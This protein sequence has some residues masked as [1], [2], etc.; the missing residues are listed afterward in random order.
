MPAAVDPASRARRAAPG[1]RALA[2]V[3]V[4][5]LLGLLAACSTGKDAVDQ[6]AGG[7]Q[8]FVSGD[9]R[10]SEYAPADRTA[11][12]DVTGTLLDGGAFGLASYRGK[13]VVV[14]FWGSW[15][16]PCRAE[17]D[18]LESVYTATK[19]SGVQ[20]VGVNVRDSRDNAVAFERS[21]KVTYPSLF[22]P[23]MRV[24]LKF[25]KTPPNGIPSTVVLDRKGRVAV[26]LRQPLISDELKPIVERIAAEPA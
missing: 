15:C 1:R 20:F 14:N 22:D 16:A 3:L 7:A 5:L 17:A 18:D 6:E 13:V 9:G 26:V 23:S 8:R 4:C 2:G 25:R 21:F 24:A 11:P 10:R 12:P 19:A